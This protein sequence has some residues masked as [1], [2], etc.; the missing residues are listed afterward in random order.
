MNFY[1]FTKRREVLGSN[2]NIQHYQ[3][4]TKSEKLLKMSYSE[5]SALN[6]L[7][8]MPFPYI[9]EKN[10]HGFILKVLVNTSTDMY[11]GI[12]R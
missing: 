11:F 10:P 4:P 3:N 5:F 2:F 12:P 7:W 9:F 1:P 6:I 8:T